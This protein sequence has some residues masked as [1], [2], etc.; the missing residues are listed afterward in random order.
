MDNDTYENVIVVLMLSIGF[1]VGMLATLLNK[2][3]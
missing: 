2:G 1:L 3:R